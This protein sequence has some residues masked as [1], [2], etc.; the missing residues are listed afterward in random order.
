MSKVD[1]SLDAFTGLAQTQPR[2]VDLATIRKLFEVVKNRCV[3]RYE[4]VE[5]A[6]LVGIEGDLRKGGMTFPQFEKLMRTLKIT[7][8]ARY[9]R[10]LYDRMVLP[11]EKVAGFEEFQ[12]ALMETT[13]LKLK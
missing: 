1:T 5:E 10:L 4:S 9:L 6:Y 3:Q 12:K 2:K 11:G 7:V 8:E 13:L